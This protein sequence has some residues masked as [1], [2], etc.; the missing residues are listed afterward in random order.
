MANYSCKYFRPRPKAYCMLSQYIHYR[1]T[2]DDNHANS[3]IVA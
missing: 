2:D 1:R 3:S